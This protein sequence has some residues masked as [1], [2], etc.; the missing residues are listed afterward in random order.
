MIDESTNISSIGHVV[1]FGTFVEEGLPISIFLGLFGVPN[2]K[3]DASLICEGLQKRIK[4]WGLEVEKC[5]SFGS[6]GCST[7]VGHLTGVSTRLKVVSSFLINI[8]CIAH[9]TN[10]AALQVA[11]C[12]DYKTLSSEIDNMINL[13][14]EMFKRSGKKKFALSA[15]QKELNDAQKSL[16]RFH[17]IRWLCRYQ[18][19][20]TLCDSL[21]SV[22][23]FLKDYPRSK[24]E[25]TTPLLYFKLRTFKYIYILYFLA[26]L[27]HNL[28][29]LSKVF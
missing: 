5:I 2:N 24:D 20:S 29:V 14:A 6:D 3:M 26:N 11:Q 10:L 21:E 19:I 12:V 9:R 18:A 8:H 7:M 15:L 27:L 4:E 1:V 23:V 28:S 22:L 16:Q 17:K 13:L 25:V